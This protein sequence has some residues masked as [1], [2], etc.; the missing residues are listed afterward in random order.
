MSVHMVWIESMMTRRGRRA[1][2]QRC[3]DV[4]DRGLGGEL[5][6]GAGETEPFGAQPHLRDRLFAR[7]IDRALLAL[8]ASAAATW[9]SSVDLPMPGSPPSSSTEPR[10]KPPPVTRSNSAMPEARR[11]A[12]C[13]SPAS[14]SSAKRRP[15]R[16]ARPGTG[17][18]ALGAFLGDACSI[19]RRRR[20]CP[21]SARKPRRS[22]GRRSC[23]C[24]GP[25][26]V[27]LNPAGFGCHFIMSGCHV[28]HAG[29][30]G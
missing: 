16:G 12:S 25:R 6:R 2:G 1:L 14:G 29:A 11:G 27:V 22:S 30:L 4:F 20:T 26:R 8:R 28:R 23:R 18:R 17:G 3:D 5:D 15:L 19:R 10:T 9:M 24:D 7:D 13:A 21:A